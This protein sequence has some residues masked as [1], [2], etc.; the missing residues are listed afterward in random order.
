MVIYLYTNTQ[1][2]EPKKTKMTKVYLN[3]LGFSF[4]IVRGGVPIELLK[5]EAKIKILLTACLMGTGEK[6]SS[7]GKSFLYVEYMSNKCSYIQNYL[8][9]I[10]QSEV[11]CHL[12]K[13]NCFYIELK[14]E[15]LN[16][17]VDSWYCDGKKTFSNKLDSS[18]LSVDAIFIWIHLFGVR[19]LESLEVT[20]SV[21]GEGYIKNL[22][23]C[24]GRHLDLVILPNRRS[25]K[26][27]QVK[28]VF[29][30]TLKY[31]LKDSIL[32]A[33]LLTKKE[34]KQIMESRKGRKKKYYDSVY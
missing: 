6:I 30:K 7:N 26:F 20:T 9:L 31:S 5:Y 25:I 34:V 32:I 28:E 18:L 11:I 4:F 15:T 13:K 12:P 14:T 27:P 10:D 23:Y 21:A 29:Y 8:P 2:G 24:I 17:L 16:E 33:S 22:I 1:L 19:R 3:F